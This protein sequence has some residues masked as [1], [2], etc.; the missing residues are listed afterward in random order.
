MPSTSC[1]G[2]PKG[3]IIFCLLYLYILR[4]SV[5]SKGVTA[6]RNVCTCPGQINELNSFRS[7]MK[8][9]MRFINKVKFKVPYSADSEQSS[10][11]QCK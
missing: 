10:V 9:E 7:S 3:I 1:S 5:P 2:S 6:P 4:F 11:R 8:G